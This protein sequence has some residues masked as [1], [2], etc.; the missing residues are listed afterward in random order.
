[1][2]AVVCGLYFAP[3][4]NFSISSIQAEMIN[5]EQPFFIVGYLERKDKTIF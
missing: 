5:T 2:V 1:M 4:L 3:L